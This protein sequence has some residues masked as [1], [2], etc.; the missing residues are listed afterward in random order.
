MM[1]LG[2]N[3]KIMEKVILNLIYGLVVIVFFCSCP[4]DPERQWDAEM[5]IENNSIDTIIFAFYVSESFENSK[6]IYWGNNYNS[7]K[8]IVHPY[9]FAIHE[10]NIVSCSYYLFNLD[11]IRTIPWER[12]RDERIILKE[13]IFHS[14]E[15]MEDCNFTITYP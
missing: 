5:I 15:E 9:S 8:K 13:V 11:S 6:E 10:L 3:F 4:Y 1:P 12:I 2:K 14:W 7:S